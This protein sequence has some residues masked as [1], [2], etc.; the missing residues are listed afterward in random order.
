[1]RKMLS[2]LGDLQWSPY[3]DFICGTEE[4]QRRIHL[5]IDLVIQ[6]LEG[7][8]ESFF[9]DQKQTG[10]IR[11]VQ[12]Y[13]LEDFLQ[14]Y[15]IFQE[16]L[17]E[18]LQEVKAKGTLK[19]VYI[20]EET[21]KLY[22]ILF[23]AYSVVTCSWVESHEEQITEKVNHLQQLY[24]FTHEIISTFELEKIVDLILRKIISLF[25]VEQSFLAIYRDGR[26][27]G[28]H[29]RPLG[30]E[31]HKIRV[32]IDQTLNQ[33]ASLNMDEWGHLSRDINQSDL[34]RLVSV[35]IQAHGRCYGVVALYDG[36]KCFKFTEK[37]LDLLYQFVHIMAVALENAFMLE[38]IEQGH[39]EL[40][41]LTNKMISIQ[42]EERRRLAGDIHDTLAQALTGISYKLQFCKELIK[43]NPELL[44]EEFDGL[45]KTVHQAMDQSRALISSL[46]PD[47]LDTIGVVP[48][49][50]RHIDNFERETGIKVSAHLP[51]NISISSEV[52]ICLFRIAQEALMNCYKHA[53]T[54]NIEVILQDN[55]V[56]A[57]LVVA[58]NGIG[59]N[60]LQGPPWLK[61]QNKLGLLSMKER[62]EAVGG[63]M[64]INTEINRGCRIE[65][66]V[67]LS[68]QPSH[69]TEN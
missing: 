62:A 51:E 47:L 10:Y 61:D 6:S 32:I 67:P 30:H 26:L 37:R 69:D 42:E 19:R 50:R 28:I 48:A 63:R 2:R 53:H 64:T 33:G 41:L 3:Q 52:S 57:I 60:M 17:W 56:D 34:K 12:G 1:M 35:P 39:E 36:K 58:D 66:S 54:K 27:Q 29:S 59:F 40:R 21:S 31:K 15:Y 46:R 49:I 22:K 4:G 23:K 16:M 65:A 7:R 13:K 24:D 14:I 9:L 5:W 43:K 11:A 44:A 45:T 18:M 68:F 38:E 8:P 55:G 25:G 20:Y